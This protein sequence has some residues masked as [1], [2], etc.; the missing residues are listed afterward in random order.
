MF[1]RRRSTGNAYAR[2]ALR[3]FAKGYEVI[4]LKRFIFSLSQ[5]HTE[6]VFAGTAHL[7]DF[8]PLSIGQNLEGGGSLVI[9][10][11]AY[12]EVGGL[13]RGTV[14]FCDQNDD[15]GPEEEARPGHFTPGDILAAQPAENVHGREHE[16]GQD[17]PGDCR[18]EEPGQGKGS[19]GVMDSGRQGR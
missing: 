16:L 1:F 11:R 12:E 14:G 6:K 9:A 15:D 18:G 7:T 5:Q 2:E 19:Q 3:Q 17:H 10:R 4:N 8:A 13:E